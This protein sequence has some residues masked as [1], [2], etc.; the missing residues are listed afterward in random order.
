LPFPSDTSTATAAASAAITIHATAA[1]AILIGRTP[2]TI[3]TLRAYPTSRAYRIRLRTPASTS[4]ITTSGS[5]I[6]RS[7][8]AAFYTLNS[9]KK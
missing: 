3:A 9:T 4:T 7:T 8:T 5:A 2:A 6:S 1:T